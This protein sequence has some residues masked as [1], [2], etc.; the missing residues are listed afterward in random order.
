MHA[1]ATD[2]TLHDPTA[3]AE[4]DRRLARFA[5]T[6]DPTEL[7]PGLRESER[8]AAAREIER[9]VRALLAGAQSDV[10]DPRQLLRPYAIAIAAHTTGM[11][12]ALGAWLEEGRIAASPEHAERLAEHLHHARRRSARITAGVLPL[13][14]ALHARGITP[15]VLKGFHTARSLFAEPGLRRMSDV[16]LL[17]PAEQRS[18][19]EQAFVAANFARHGQ[20]F[21]SHKQDWI[22]S[23]VSTRAHSVELSDEHSVWT[24]EMHTS[25]DC[26]FHRGSVA[27]LDA[28]R[29]HTEP[30]E[31]AG[32]PV[33]VLR[34]DAQLITLACHCAK[35]LG[36][37]RLLRLYELILAVRTA[38]ARGQL[39]W[40]AVESLL[41]AT[42]AARF[43]W[44]ALS[45]AEDL[46]PGTIPARILELGRRESTWAARH[47]VP[48]LAPAGGAIGEL[49]FIRQIMWARGAGAVV[50]RAQRLL[51]PA[52]WA[53][54]RRPASGWRVRLHQ[55]RSGQLSLRAPDERPRQRR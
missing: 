44:P 46:A 7:W 39:D 41:T 9:V 43:A 31:I 22:A 35:E 47:T 36:S 52:P 3:L 10:L 30:W 53:A 40:T 48:R 18:S 12:P 17:V 8:V 45:L 1:S 50:Q 16:D 49:G 55:L 11:G 25:L 19:A 51:W 13:L 29:S 4:L 34:P 26:I 14:D 28:L 32:R 20:S 5:A 23:G 21:E 15:L 33:Q 38:T 2:W 24:V 54:P 37:S 6:N 27:H 42:R